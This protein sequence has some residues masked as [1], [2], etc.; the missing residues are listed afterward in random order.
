MIAK[1]FY[2]L[3]LFLFGI[4]Y[5]KS[6]DTIVLKNG[7]TIYGLITD[8]KNGEIKFRIDGGSIQMNQIIN[9]SKPGENIIVN[10]SSSPGSMSTPNINTPISDC[11]RKNIGDVEFENKSQLTA[12]VRV[13]A[14]GLRPESVT[15]GSENNPLIAGITVPA[16]G[17]MSAFDLTVGTHYISYDFNGA[18]FEGQIRITKCGVFKMALNVEK[19]GW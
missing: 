10:A 15:F 14:I 2:L 12:T 9:Y 6:Q 1:R 18:V 16:N 7:L 19:S 3:T 13:F 4:L 8:V 17:K 11:E 5:G